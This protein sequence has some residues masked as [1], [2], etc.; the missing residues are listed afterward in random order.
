MTQTEVEGRFTLSIGVPRPQHKMNA[1]QK[2]KNAVV[3]KLLQQGDM[4]AGS[5][6]EV[7]K[8][9]RRQLSE[10]MAD[11]GTSHFDDNFT[12]ETSAAE[13]ENA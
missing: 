7:R 11:A 6:A 2:A 10:L 8:S 4:S 9:S 12:A 3:L 13:V 5:A 1:E